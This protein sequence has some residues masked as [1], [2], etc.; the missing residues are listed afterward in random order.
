MD[1]D[2]GY[3]ATVVSCLMQPK[4]QRNLFGQCVGITSC[5]HFSVALTWPQVVAAGLADAYLC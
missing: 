1:E 5:V 4:L 3:Q 2:P